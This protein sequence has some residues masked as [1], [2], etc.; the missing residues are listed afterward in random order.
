MKNSVKS[1]SFAGA[2][3]ACLGEARPNRSVCLSSL[4]AKCAKIVKKNFNSSRPL[5]SWRFKKW[6]CAKIR[7]NESQ[8]ST[9]CSRIIQTPSQRIDVA[10][11]PA[12]DTERAS[13]CRVDRADQHRHLQPRRRCGSLGGDLH[14]LDRDP[15]HGRRRGPA[16]VVG[17]AGLLDEAVTGNHAHLHR[18]RAR[19]RP[20]RRELH[21]TRNG[22][23]GQARAVP[24]WHRRERQGIFWKKI[25]SRDLTGFRENPINNSFIPCGELRTQR[26]E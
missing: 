10:D 26:Y 5:R 18:S 1:T 22:D 4:T 25:N 19:L 11:S 14:D 15:G 13:F 8:N 3:L 20:S 6:G 12:C 17:R 9:A 7:L 2:V 21:Q 16:C 23:G 24:R